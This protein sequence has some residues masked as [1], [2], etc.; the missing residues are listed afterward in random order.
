MQVW[1]DVQT[2]I[3]DGHLRRVT[4]TRYHIGTI[5]TPDDEHLYARNM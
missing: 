3:P 5:E 1:T 4:Y 2:C